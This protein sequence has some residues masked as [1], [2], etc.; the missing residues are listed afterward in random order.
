MAAVLTNSTPLANLSKGDGLAV[1]AKNLA[2]LGGTN[3]TAHYSPGP[4]SMLASSADGSKLVAGS[5]GGQIYT[6]TDGGEVWN[7]R[8]TAR[9]WQSVASSVDGSKLVAVAVGGQIYT[10]TDSGLSWTARD[11]ARFW[12][13]VATS[14]DG[15]KLAAVAYNGQIYTSVTWISST[16]NFVNG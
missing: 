4:W 1:K 7:A 5:W 11:S 16:T 8:E 6:S 10:S 9:F 15:S 2:V 14:A 3:W 13:S 12:Q